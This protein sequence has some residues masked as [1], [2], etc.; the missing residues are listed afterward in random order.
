MRVKLID[1]NECHECDGVFYTKVDVDADYCPYCGKETAEH[2]KEME[3]VV[4]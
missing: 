1:V 3:I 2:V 4:E